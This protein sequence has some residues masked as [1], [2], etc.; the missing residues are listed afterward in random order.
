MND[1]PPPLRSRAEFDAALNSLPFPGNE[2][3]EPLSVCLVSGEKDHGPGEH[4]YE[5]WQANWKALLSQAPGVMVDT[6][7]Q[8]PQPSQ[9][10]TADLV[11]LYFWN[12]NWTPDRYADLDAFLAR[13]GGVVVLHSAMVEDDDPQKLAERFG[14]AGQRPQLQFRHG[15]LRLDVDDP[16]AHPIMRG[17]DNLYLVDETYWE[18]Q[19]DPSKVEVEV[20]ATSLEA[21]RVCPMLWTHRVNDGRVFCSVPG[22]YA[23]TFEDPIYRLI[24]LRAMAWAVGGDPARFQALA[25]QGINFASE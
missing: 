21:E 3:P 15:P 6:A 9:W 13:G 18:L 4:E 11:V 2:S 5:L 16:S 7:F 12:H 8:W 14:L 25:S 19:G 24:L 22:H 10:H 20:L 1:T 23:W 17:I